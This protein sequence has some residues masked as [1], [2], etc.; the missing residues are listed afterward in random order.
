MFSDVFRLLR[1]INQNNHDAISHGLHTSFHFAQSK[2]EACTVSEHTSPV[3]RTH[4]FIW[5]TLACP[6]RG[7]SLPACQQD[8]RDDVILT[9][10]PCSYVACACF[11][12]EPQCLTYRQASLSQ[13]TFQ[14]LGIKGDCVREGP[15]PPASASTT[16][17]QD[18]CLAWTYF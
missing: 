15:R 13:A 14:G 17:A 4:W 1:A 16:T 2:K 12:S 11:S 9:R 7:V 18:Q 6:S 10:Q 8:A 3:S 5:W